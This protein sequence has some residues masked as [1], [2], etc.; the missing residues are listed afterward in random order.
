MGSNHAIRNSLTDPGLQEESLQIDESALENELENRITSLERLVDGAYIAL[1]QRSFSSKGGGLDLANDLRVKIKAN[2]NMFRVAKLL[3]EPA[4][5]SM[6]SKVRDSVAGLEEV[7]A[8]QFG[9][10][11]N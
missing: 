1:G 10:E 11:M 8:S 9:V 4:R 5:G 6:L 7:V 2:H 3:R